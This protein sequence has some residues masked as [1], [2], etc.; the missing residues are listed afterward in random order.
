MSAMRNGDMGRL[1]GCDPS[2]RAPRWRFPGFFGL[3]LLLL[4]QTGCSPCRGLDERFA[5][6]SPGD[7]VTERQLV[8]TASLPGLARAGG[9]GFVPGS[10]PVGEHTVRWQ[11]LAT[12]MTERGLEAAATVRLESRDAASTGTWVFPLEVRVKPRGPGL[13]LLLAP[14][15]PGTL[16]LPQA[17]EGLDVDA[18]LARAR[19]SWLD[20]PVASLP[21]WFRPGEYLELHPG[22]LDV[23]GL[24][25][26]LPI[27][28]R[29][30]G[31][32]AT[33]VARVLN[34]GLA[35]DL[36]LAVSLPV[37][38]ALAEGG[39]RPVSPAPAPE[40]AGWQV[41]VTKLSSTERSIELAASARSTEV[42][43]FG[44]VESSGKL[45]TT[46]G[47]LAAQSVQVRSVDD[48]GGAPLQPGASAVAGQGW[49]QVVAA[50]A[51]AVK[52]P[53]NAPY[54]LRLVRRHAQTLLLDGLL[55]EPRP[56]SRGPSP[57]PPGG[58]LRTPSLR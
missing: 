41:R 52:G 45:G 10:A 30:P 2:D 11:G 50:L 17:P 21:G 51:G 18:V 26:R 43:G 12:R 4:V 1:L 36:S 7:E 16:S 15:G 39:W 40:E 42:C 20:A 54:T 48:E 44:T 6:P 38:A 47:A 25:A 49:A 23:G 5:L 33:D 35:E 55:R 8:L 53:E 3:A 24:V 58:P 29:L 56:P 28:T 9:A 57:A 14:A 19:R 37:L 27:G 31:E 13:D 22:P 32:P 46:Q 34:P